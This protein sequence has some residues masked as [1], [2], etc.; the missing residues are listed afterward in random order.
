[1]CDAIETQI[2][3]HGFSYDEAIAYMLGEIPANYP[4]PATDDDAQ[5]MIALDAINWN[6]HISQGCEMCL[7]DWLDTLDTL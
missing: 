5:L 7:N 6:K 2:I 4:V 3:E 1:M